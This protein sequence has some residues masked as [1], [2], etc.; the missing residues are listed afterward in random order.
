MLDN[1]SVNKKNHNNIVSVSS[2]K[3]NKKI[4][5]RFGVLTKVNRDRDKMKRRE[6]INRKGKSQTRDHKKNTTY[7]I[8]SF[9]ISVHPGLRS[10]R[11][12]VE[13]LSR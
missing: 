5:L 4:V 1:A 8:I 13:Y 2:N 10:R 3:I 12:E 9:S 7:V 6:R 11:R